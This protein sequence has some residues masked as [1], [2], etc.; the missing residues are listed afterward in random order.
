MPIFPFIAR[1][2]VEVVYIP[3]VSSPLSY[4]SIEPIL[5]S[6]PSILLPCLHHKA[7]CKLTEDIRVKMSLDIFQSVLLQLTQFILEV[8]RIASRLCAISMASH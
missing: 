7:L 2:S 5:I 8:G 3:F 4:S 6:I 1:L